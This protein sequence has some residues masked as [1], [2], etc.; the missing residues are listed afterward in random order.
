MNCVATAG[1]CFLCM[2][3]VTSVEQ[4]ATAQQADFLATVRK[5]WVAR[6]TK[7]KSFDVAWNEMLT[8][9]RGMRGRSGR[10][11]PI[12]SETVTHAISHR[13]A[14]D[15]N[16]VRW[17]RSGQQWDLEANDFIR[18]DFTRVFDGQERR[19]FFQ[20]PQQ[21]GGRGGGFL[22]DDGIFDGGDWHIQP[23]ILTF[24]PLA[25]VL[26]GIDL[27][28]WHLT[29]QRGTVSDIPCRILQ[30][31][32]T[33]HV[34]ERLWLADAEDFRI[35]RRELFVTDALRTRIDM[36]CEGR[37]GNELACKSWT[38]ADLAEDGTVRESATTI[39]PRVLTNTPIPAA[40]F[41]FQFP[42][43][44]IVT[45]E[46]T[47]QRAV[48]RT[49]GSLRPVANGELVAGISPEEL[50]TMPPPKE[51]PPFTTTRSKTWVYLTL[52]V[53]VGALAVIGWL[54]RRHG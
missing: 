1:M 37:V 51:V 17:T 25:I 22:N 29:E 35:L 41:V 28:V 38:Y 39:D 6:E 18:K 36:V 8:T 52:A 34:F 33:E 11:E 49:D 46:R 19:E 2:S 48:A 45:H 12:P 10:G 50:M 43:G 27:N 15:G 23:V 26:G 20:S 42:T 44:T 21:R 14:C 24:R 40:E 54:F 5:T 31:T 3:I 53:V 30:W 13:L 7:F 47:N 16:R 9:P 32:R 4:P